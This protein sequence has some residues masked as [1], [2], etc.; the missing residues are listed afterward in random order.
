MT[1]KTP[2]AE[3]TR[4]KESRRRPWGGGGGGGGGGGR[5]G[6]PVQFGRS[7]RTRRVFS[8]LDP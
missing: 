6:P 1:D 5:G 3:K 8:S 4:E 7:P 2:R